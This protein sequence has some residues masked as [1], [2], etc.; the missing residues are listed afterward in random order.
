MFMAAFSGTSIYWDKRTGFLTKLLASPIPRTSI[1][2][3]KITSTAIRS[4]MQG[5][6]MLTLCPLVG[7]KI[8]TGFYALLTL[9]FLILLIMGFSGISTAVG[10]KISGYEF[11]EVM[12]LFLMPIF[13]LSGAIIPI[14]VMPN[15][16]Q[17]IAQFNPLTYA[18]EATRKLMLGGELGPLGGGFAVIDISPSLLFDTSVLL[19]FLAGSLLIAVTLARKALI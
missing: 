5:I 11:F 2:L 17:A 10:L 15:W 6:I 8:N 3:G 4:L 13:F 9:P 14:Q 18:V 19:L 16:L 7:V 1:I 12:N